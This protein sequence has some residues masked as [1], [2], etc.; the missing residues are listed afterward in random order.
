MR[1]PASHEHKADELKLEI[2]SRRLAA[3]IGE[4]E[5]GEFSSRDIEEIA[6]AVLAEDEE[7]DAK[8]NPLTS[9]ITRPKG[10]YISEVV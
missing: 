2:L 3:A 9:G 6:A 1:D 4:A 5:R 7:P 10:R 8:P